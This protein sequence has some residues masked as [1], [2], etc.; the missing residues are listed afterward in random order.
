MPSVFS[1]YPFVKTP[2]LVSSKWNFR[3]LGLYGNQNR[4]AIPFWPCQHVC[5]V[6]RLQADLCFV[7]IKN[8]FN[9]CWGHELC[10]MESFSNQDR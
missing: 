5:L 6:S 10:Y 4:S 7:T 3:A 1:V 8:H 9:P 2:V